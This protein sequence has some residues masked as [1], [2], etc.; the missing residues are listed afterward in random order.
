VSLRPP[1]GS[2]PPITAT[3]DELPIDLG[4]LAREICERYYRF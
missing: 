4:S 3:I 1:S 2:P